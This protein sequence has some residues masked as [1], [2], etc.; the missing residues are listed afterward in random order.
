MKSIIALL[1]LA[2]FPISYGEEIEGFKSKEFESPT[3]EYS[4]IATDQG[5]FPDRLFAYVGEKA[6]FFVTSTSKSPQ[7]FLLQDHKIFLAAEKGKMQEGSVTFRY[8]GRFEFY[9]PST[10]FKGHVTVVERPG[11]KKKKQVRDVASVK[12]D[13]WTPKDY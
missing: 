13:Y 3:R 11:A 8:P 5:Y 10:K 7:C 4:V 2:A 6:R 12:K 1:V 9:C